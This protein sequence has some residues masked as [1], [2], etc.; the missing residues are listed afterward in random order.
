MVNYMLTGW[1]QTDMG[2]SGGRCADI[3]V[4]ESASGIIDVV[5]RTCALQSEERYGRDNGVNQEMKEF[6]TVLLDKNTNSNVLF[7]NYDGRLMRW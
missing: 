6:E 1:V 3:S 4:K 5:N 2:N 7:V